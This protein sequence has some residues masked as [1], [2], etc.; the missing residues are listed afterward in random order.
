MSKTSLINRLRFSSLSYLQ[1][2]SDGRTRVSSADDPDFDTYWIY[3]DEPI[4]PTPKESL[5]D[6]GASFLKSER[7]PDGKSYHLIGTENGKLWIQELRSNSDEGARESI[8]LK[9]EELTRF[10]FRIRFFFREV[11]MEYSDPIVAALQRRTK[12]VYL[13]LLQHRYQ[14][15][16]ADKSLRLLN[17]RITTIE[18]LIALEDEERC[19]GAGAVQLATRIHGPAYTLAKG[20]RRLKLFRQIVRIL[21]SLVATGEL[22]KRELLYVTTGKAT[23]T[24]FE[25]KEDKKK[26]EDSRAMQRLMFGATCVIAFS[27][28]AQLEIVTKEDIYSL[29]G[30]ISSVILRLF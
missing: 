19:R 22:E 24:L 12:W 3:L 6:D 5:I 27:A 23:A 8:S 26:H 11:E 16:S 25:Y 1:R 15:W 2:K 18:A 9:P 10:D 20:E 7:V 13:L 21:D 17:E 14:R 29:L 30:N 28:V 4:P